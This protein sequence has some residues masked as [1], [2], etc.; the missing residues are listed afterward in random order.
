[1]KAMVLKEFTKPLVL[2]EVKEPTYGPRE[3]LLKVKAAGVCGTDLKIRDGLVPTKELPLIPGHEVAGVVAAIGNEVESFREGDEVLVSFYIPCQQCRNCLCGRQT[4]CEQLKGRIGFEFD[5]GFAE[6]VA[7]PEACL[8]PKPKELSFQQAAVIPDALGTCYHALVRRAQVKK[9]DCIVVLGGGGGLG[10]HAIQIA[11][12]LGAVVIGVDITEDKLRLMQTYGAD[13]VIDG[14]Q[15]PFWSKTV[16]AYT[17]GLKAD[18]VV[19]FI[20]HQP[21]I[22]EGLKALRKGGNLVLVA[23]SKEFKFDALWGHLNEIDLLSTRA[24][25]KEEIGACLKL[26]TEQKVQPVLDKVIKLEELNEGLQLIKDGKLKGR[27]VVDIE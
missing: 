24:A 3:V 16:S 12:G 5:G 21:S 18:H 7:V 9:G 10:L 23:Y 25:T 1:M 4:I 27:L 8:I 14:E 11:K 2:T 19:N 20:T 22:D 13:F 15:D 17:H 6:Y 26:V